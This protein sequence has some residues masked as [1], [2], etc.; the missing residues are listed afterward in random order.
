MAARRLALRMEEGREVILLNLQV[1]A[2]GRSISAFGG[3][4]LRNERVVINCFGG[5]S[6]RV[7]AEQ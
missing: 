2:R 3:I 4:L 6:R 7:E 5:G 1:A